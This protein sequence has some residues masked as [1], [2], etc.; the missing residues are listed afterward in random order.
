MLVGLPYLKSKLDLFYNQVSGGSSV[1]GHSEQEERERDEL[2]DPSTRPSRKLAIRLVRLFRKIYPFVNA[3]Y[4]VAHLLYNIGY[5]FGKTRYYTPW[6]HLVGLEI[7]RMSMAD[8]VSGKKKR[9][10]MHACS[11]PYQD[12]S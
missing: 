12:P 6:L 10:M 9:K 11:A 5:L 8:Y 2:H 4:H 3:L 7:R 1:L